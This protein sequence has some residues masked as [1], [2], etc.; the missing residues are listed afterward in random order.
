MEKKVIYMISSLFYPSIGG[1]ENHIYNLSKTLM[2]NNENI[3][4]KILK[5]VINLKK[6]NIYFLDGIEVHEISVGNGRDEEIYNNFK[7]KSKG[8][9]IGF[10]YGYRRKS[11]FNRYRNEIYQYIEKEIQKEKQKFIIHQHDFISNIML[12]KMLAKKYKVIFTNHTGEYLFLKKI[13]IINNILI[14][15]LTNHFSYI[16]GPSDEL[17]DFEKIRNNNTFC[18]LPNG[19]D[20]ERFLMV[21]NEEKLE[22]RKKMN[23]SEDEIIVFSPRRWAPTKGI[24]YL[25]KAI[26]EII[27]QTDKNIKFYF[28]GNDYGDYKE[29]R[30][31]ILNYID[32]NNLKKYIVFLGNVDYQKIDSY[33]K[34]SDV[35][36][37][38]SLMEAVSLGALEAM[39]CGKIM[40]GTKVGGFPQIITSGE[41]GIL[42]ESKNEKEITE[43][44]L[45]I[46]EN[47]DE[48]KN[49]G[50]NARKF[51]EVNYSWN[52][53]ARKTMEIYSNFYNEF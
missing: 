20:T 33:Y 23:I 27:N 6:N 16:I 40:I 14:K 4:V 38:P 35:V 7:E 28:A 29:Y 44:I 31:E 8:N 9:L 52:E 53:I 36:I 3:L 45:K 19:V 15:I 22:L 48:Y 41:N 2:L 1:V 34:I 42:I 49:L 11:F 24:I 17:S 13:P 25:V 39:S 47:L 30:Q 21:S 12:S 46:S 50:I 37:L 26:K 18:Y 10:F 43:I 5:P 32:E 51:V